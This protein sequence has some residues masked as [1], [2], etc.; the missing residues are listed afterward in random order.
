MVHGIIIHGRSFNMEL[1]HLR[2]GVI[3]T[4]G[5]H[6]RYIVAVQNT[7]PVPLVIMREEELYGDLELDY[8]NLY[9]HALTLPQAEEI[10]EK[11]KEEKNAEGL[12]QQYFDDSGPTCEGAGLTTLERAIPDEWYPSWEKME[13]IATVSRNYPGYFETQV[14]TFDYYD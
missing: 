8:Y 1:Y 3:L 11:L 14:E 12:L 7:I 10:L 9:E 13:V 2:Y 5:G 6:K 4:A